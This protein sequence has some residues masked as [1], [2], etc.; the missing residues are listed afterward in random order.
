MG[1]YTDMFAKEDKKPFVSSFDKQWDDRKNKIA[2]FKKF[3]IGGI[4][5]GFV[6][7]VSFYAT[8][9][10]FAMDE[11]D[12][13]GGVKNTIVKYGKEIKDISAAIDDTN[14]EN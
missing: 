9:A 4:I 14:S 12:S 13:N 7:I 3:V 1:K 5:T 8:L 11:I 10:Y 6:I 2:R